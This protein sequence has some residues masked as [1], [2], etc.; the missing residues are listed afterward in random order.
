MNIEEERR[1]RERVRETEV[2]GGKGGEAYFVYVFLVVV[3][4]VWS[5]Q[6]RPPWF[7]E[8]Q[9]TAPSLLDLPSPLLL[10]LL[11]VVLYW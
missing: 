2:R 7:R 9:Q 10:L 5:P 11:L 4:R 3:C 8:G 6:E 1:G